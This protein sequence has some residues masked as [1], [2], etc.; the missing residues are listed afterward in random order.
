MSGTSRK[1]HLMQKRSAARL[2]AVQALYQQEQLGCSYQEVY[3]DFM[4]HRLYQSDYEDHIALDTTLFSNIL[5]SVHSSS[6][7]IE[8][9]ITDH[10]S[11]DWSYHRLEIV[12]R[13]ILRA[14]IAE[15]LM[16]KDLPAAIIINEYMNVARGFYEG[17]EAQFINGILDKV[18]RQLNLCMKDEGGR[19]RKIT[20]PEHIKKDYDTSGVPNWR[21]EGGS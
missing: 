16:D 21:D 18:A 3:K 15:F 2:A 9:L 10:L 4:T 8:S 14:A 5:L 11:P 13:C 19:T 17:R 6:E 7:R 1:K 12:L 20:N